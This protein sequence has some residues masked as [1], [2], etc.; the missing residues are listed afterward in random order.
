MLKWTVHC[1]LSVE[2]SHL[3]SQK[4]FY[5]TSVVDPQLLYVQTAAVDFPLVNFQLSVLILLSVASPIK[6]QQILI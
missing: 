2:E 1:A 3:L 4:T 6:L 5:R